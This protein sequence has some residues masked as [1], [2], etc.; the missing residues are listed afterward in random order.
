[1]EI[2]S[3]HNIAP[4]DLK[5]FI[6][7]C[8]LGRGDIYVCI[9]ITLSSFC[10]LGVVVG[11]AIGMAVLFFIIGFGAVYMFYKRNGGSFVKSDKPLENPAYENAT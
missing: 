10:L 6:I 4:F 3:E 11:L 1:L 9:K 2:F 8:L 7:F 5:Y